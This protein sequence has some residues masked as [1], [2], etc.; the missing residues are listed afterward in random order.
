M[1]RNLSLTFALMLFTARLL[2]QDTSLRKIDKKVARIEAY[3]S[4]DVIKI[5][6]PVDL[7]RINSNLLELTN[8]SRHKDDQGKI[9]EKLATAG[10]HCYRT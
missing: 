6:E 4:Y 2:A 1:R 10:G 7:K 5:D 9:E 3:P 8:Y